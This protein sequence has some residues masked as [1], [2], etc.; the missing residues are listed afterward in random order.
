MLPPE[1]A[2]QRKESLEST[3]QEGH[4]ELPGGAGRCT[5]A[6]TAREP[7]PQSRR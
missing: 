6:V 1:S 5:L 3:G 2:L 4:S 7:Y